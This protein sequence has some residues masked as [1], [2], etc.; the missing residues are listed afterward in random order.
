M[1]ISPEQETRGRLAA[2][3]QEPSVPMSGSAKE[4]TDYI[5]NLR[6]TRTATF[7]LTD[8][9]FCPKLKAAGTRR[10]NSIESVVRNWLI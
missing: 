10:A 7:Y 8:I 6:K 5:R 2:H 1:D 3:L 9:S 4:T